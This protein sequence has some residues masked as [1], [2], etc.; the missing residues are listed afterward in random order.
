MDDLRKEALS[1]SDILIDDN[2][3][4]LIRCNTTESVK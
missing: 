2:H 3:I 4:M 1:G